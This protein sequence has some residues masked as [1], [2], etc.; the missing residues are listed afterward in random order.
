[1]PFRSGWPEEPA[2][3]P[4]DVLRVRPKQDGDASR[5]GATRDDIHIEIA[6][7]HEEVLTWMRLSLSCIETTRS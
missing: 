7:D 2:G 3:V 4:D 1:M 5:N 6:I